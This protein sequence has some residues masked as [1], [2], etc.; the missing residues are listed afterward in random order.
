M[1]EWDQ[2]PANVWHSGA[3]AATLDWMEMFP[4][5][6]GKNFDGQRYYN[7]K[8]AQKDIFSNRD[9]R[10]YESMLVQKKDYKWQLYGPSNPVQLWEGG[11]FAI[12]GGTWA[13]ATCKPH[14]FPTYKFV[15]DLGS[16]DQGGQGIIDDEPVQYAYIRLAE[17]Y[18]IYAEALA[19]TGQM[20]KALEQLNIVRARVGLPKIETAKPCSSVSRRP[21]S[22][23]GFRSIAEGTLCLCTL[24]I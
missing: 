15:L 3:I 24:W 8:P 16:D 4:W 17:I 1:L 13:A 21:D 12:S 2:C 11:E 9:P 10:L 22:Q 14:G 20:A 5:A 19:E 18:L 23:A 6:D 7:Q